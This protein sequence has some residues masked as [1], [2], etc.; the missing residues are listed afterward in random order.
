MKHSK[1]EISANKIGYMC[2]LTEKL[3]FTSLT[4]I[5][6]LVFVAV[7]YKNILKDD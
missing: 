3:F 5:C 2:S 6:I 4:E 7:N 1:T